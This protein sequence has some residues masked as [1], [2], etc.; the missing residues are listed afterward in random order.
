MLT[1]AAIGT[2]LLAV[3][4]SKTQT[5][6][7]SSKIPTKITKNTTVTFWY[8]LTGSSE[9]ALKK[10]TADFEKENPKIKIKLESQGGNYADLQSKLSSTMQSPDNLPTIRLIQDG[11]I[12]LLSKKC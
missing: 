11:C 5:K 3:G 1:L 12:M 7:S 8:S 9:K 10:M 4:C 6:E 2:A